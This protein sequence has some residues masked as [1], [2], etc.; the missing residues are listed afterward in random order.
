MQWANKTL[1]SETRQTSRIIHAEARASM[2]GNEKLYLV[3]SS[4][5]AVRF[6]GE[7]DSEEVAW[8]AQRINVFLE[9][10]KV[11]DSLVEPITRD[12][13]QG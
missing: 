9:K 7:L 6:A 4:G 13:T 10:Q 8:L 5:F 1:E 11:K 3:S 12:A 2:E